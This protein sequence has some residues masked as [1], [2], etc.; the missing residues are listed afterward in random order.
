MAFDHVELDVLQEHSLLLCLLL[1]LLLL[2]RQRKHAVHHVELDV[3]E[4][5]DELDHPFEHVERDLL[6]HVE[7]GLLHL[8]EHV[9][10]LVEHVQLDVLELLL[11]ELVP[12]WLSRR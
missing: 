1:D 6:E 3:L 10:H 4:E 8:V 11:E 9:K 5:L 7:L 2:G 12:S